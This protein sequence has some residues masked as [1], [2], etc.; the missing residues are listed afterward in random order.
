[1][2]GWIAKGF[3]SASPALI[4]PVI[5]LAIFFTVFGLIIVYVVRMDNKE[6]EHDAKLPLNN[7][8]DHKWN[9]A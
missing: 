5:A 1:M 8:N 2:I 9:E 4:F 3:Y 6:I 7:D